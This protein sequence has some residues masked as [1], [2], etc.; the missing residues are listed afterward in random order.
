[1]KLACQ[2]GMVPGNTLEEKLENLGR[3]GYDAIEFGGRGL[4]ERVQAIS[5]ALSESA[6]KASTV[7]GGFGGCLLDPAKAERDRAV[8]D[9]KAL[10]SAAADIGAVG[11]IVVPVFGPPRLPDLSPYKTAVEIERELLVA[12]LDPL[13]A[14]AAS[15]GTLLLLEPLNRYET[16]LLRRLG[17]AAAV[18]SRLGNPNIKLMADFFHMSIEERD[19][20]AA[21]RACGQWLAHVHLADSNRLLPGFGHTDFVAGFRALRDVGFSGYMALECGVPGAPEVELP[22]CADR[23]RQMIEAATA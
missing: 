14:H 22:L 5:E 10:L 23:L 12:V 20:A 3:Y 21:I 7:C 2:E 19:V 6:V 16:H 8:A 4:P 13:G 17:D 1:M 15:V 9:I 11:V 18:C